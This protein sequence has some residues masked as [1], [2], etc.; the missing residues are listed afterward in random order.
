MHWRM[1]CMYW[2][3]AHFTARRAIKWWSSS[4]PYT[5]HDFWIDKRRTRVRQT[6]LCSSSIDFVELFLHRYKNFIW[7]LQGRYDVATWLA[8]MMEPLPFI[9]RGR[10]R[11]LMTTPCVLFMCLP[12]FVLPFCR[13][14][15]YT[16]FCLDVRLQ[17]KLKISSW[18]PLLLLQ[19]LCGE[20]IV[21]GPYHQATTTFLLCQNPNDVPA[22]WW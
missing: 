11:I 4:N 20:S 2:S 19:E 8:L 17:F 14:L 12:S 7:S 16:T 18:L 9:G 22:A 21:G 15:F 13:V 1:D 3:N 5:K 10:M 6:K